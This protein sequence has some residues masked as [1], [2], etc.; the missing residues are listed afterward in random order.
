MEKIT[1]A[2]FIKQA[3]K[4]LNYHGSRFIPGKE[5]GTTL[6]HIINN[7]ENS[8]IIGHRELTN[9]T[10]T[11]L[12]FATPDGYSYLNI[13]GK[14]CTISVFYTKKLNVFVIVDRVE[15]QAN[16]IVYSQKNRGQNN[17][18]IHTK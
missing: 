5:I 8:N 1:K 11:S 9:N 7:I 6:D 10:L 2:M 3:K 15:G 18:I 17:G 16:I 12:R 4:G 13:T 14:S